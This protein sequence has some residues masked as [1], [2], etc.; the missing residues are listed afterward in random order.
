MCWLV[1]DNPTSS[2]NLIQTKTI[3]SFMTW[4]QVSIVNEPHLCVAP[5]SSNYREI[6][7]KARHLKTSQQSL[8]ITL[9]ERTPVYSPEWYGLSQISRWCD[10]FNIT[11]FWA[12]NLL[13]ARENQ[14]CTLSWYVLLLLAHLWYW[15]IRSTIAR[16]FTC[17][18][19]ELGRLLRKLSCLAQCLIS[20]ASIASPVRTFSWGPGY[21]GY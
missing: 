11:G 8:D 1:N 13:Q 12:A 14:S 16:I 5:V 15:R 7:T 21:S 10:S 20:T 4:F 3:S 6:T 19:V 18:I 17:E 9:H 2:E